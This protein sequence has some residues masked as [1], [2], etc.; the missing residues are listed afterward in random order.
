[1]TFVDQPDMF[2]HTVDE[3]LTPPEPPAVSTATPTPG[4]GGARPAAVSPTPAANPR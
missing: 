3:F 1:M 2:I 4:A